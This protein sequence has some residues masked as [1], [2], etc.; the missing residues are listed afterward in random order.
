M[1]SEILELY[2]WCV[3]HSIPCSLTRLW[4]GYKIEFPDHSDFV[5]HEGSY[6]SK[7]GCVEPA[8]FS[9]SYAA[10]SIDTAKELIQEKSF[11]K[12]S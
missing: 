4:S 6:G 2:D 8:G 1:F 12:I 3:G 7:I 9:I 10:V 5:Q 11:G